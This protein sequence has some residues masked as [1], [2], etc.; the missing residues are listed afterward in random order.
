MRSWGEGRGSTLLFFFP[1]SSR[2]QVEKR[3]Q[4]AVVVA[5]FANVKAGVVGRVCVV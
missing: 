3:K 1:F 5:L 4:R 2:G